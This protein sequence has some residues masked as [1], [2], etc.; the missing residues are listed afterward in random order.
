M[1]IHAIELWK[2]TTRKKDDDDDDGGE[3]NNNNNNSDDD[4]AV[5]KTN[6]KFRKCMKKEI[7]SDYGTTM[8]PEIVVQPIFNTLT[9]NKYV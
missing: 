8:T 7:S 2:A 1:C 4:E 9:H 5:A 6:M 3:N